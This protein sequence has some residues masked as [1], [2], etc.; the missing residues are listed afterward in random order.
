MRK[1]LDITKKII[2]DLEPKDIPIINKIGNRMRK[3]RFFDFSIIKIDINAIV[4]V[5]IFKYK[6]AIFT[7]SNINCS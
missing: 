1:I 4:Q 5:Y 7:L 6:K 3:I 2:K